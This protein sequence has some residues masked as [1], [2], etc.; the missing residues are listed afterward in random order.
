M[1]ENIKKFLGSVSAI[2]DRLESIGWKEQS[3]RYD[4]G[5]FGNILIKFSRGNENL[6]IVKDRGHWELI[7]DDKSRHIASNPNLD[8]DQSR[9]DDFVQI[10]LLWLAR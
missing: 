4:A 3:F 6:L 2:V 1:N 9:Q 8:N 5:S 10:V 7:A